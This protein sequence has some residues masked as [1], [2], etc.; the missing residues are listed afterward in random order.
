MLFFDKEPPMKRYATNVRN[1]SVYRCVCM[2]RRNLYMT[3]SCSADG[4]WRATTSSTSNTKT[5][6]SA[7]KWF[8]P[9]T[10]PTRPSITRANSRWSCSHS[11]AL[12][13]LCSFVRPQ[14]SKMLLLSTFPR[15][16]PPL[17]SYTPT[18]L[19]YFCYPKL[20]Y[21]IVVRSTVTV[22]GVVERFESGCCV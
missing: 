18:S 4:I 3:C 19:K 1:V 10:L 21:F 5:R 20:I 15:I 6:R 17:T 14:V 22:V 12:A 11:L 13:R 16:P 9:S 8:P 2:C 7:T